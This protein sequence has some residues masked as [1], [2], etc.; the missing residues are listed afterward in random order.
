MT[1]VGI[2]TGQLARIQPS[3]AM[4]NDLLVGAR[5]PRPTWR[6]TSTRPSTTA[7]SELFRGCGAVGPL[8]ANVIPI[9][10]FPLGSRLRYL[11]AAHTGPYAKAVHYSVLCARPTTAGGDPILPAS[12]SSPAPAS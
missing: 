6:S 7:P 4:R 9:S 1:A 11:F 8:S 5:R 2:P 3:L 12:S 10:L